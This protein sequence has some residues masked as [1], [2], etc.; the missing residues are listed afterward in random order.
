[1]NN[2]AF[3]LCPLCHGLEAKVL[4]S[5][6]TTFS[7][8]HL[9]QCNMCELTRTF[10]LPNDEILRAHDIYSYYGRNV[11]KFNSRVQKIRNLIMRM[12]AKHYLNLIP[13]LTQTP[14]ILD[15]GCAEGRL[16]KSF[17]EYGCQCWGIEHTS[18]PAQR[19]LDSDRIVYLQGDLNAMNLPEGVFDLIF[20]WHALEHM[21][22]PHL[23]MS[24]LHKLLAPKGAIIIAVPNFSS[25][26]ARRFKK[27]WFHLDIPW[28]KYHFNDKSIRHLMT[29]T[30]LMIINISSF[31]SEQGP[32]GLLQSILN[33]M[34]WPKNEFYEALKGNL[35]QRRYIYIIIQLFIGL[36]LLIP[37][38]FVSFLVS[39]KGRGS[40]IKLIL[41]KG[42]H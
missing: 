18:Y 39:I 7:E 36:F 34:G 15:V 13:D 14:K 31:C 6:S 41:K 9:V 8:F 40:V 10:P 30:H 22:N 42:K 28:H 20:L 2:K 27:F 5:A 29:E 38:F 1:M 19:F 35:T 33:A 24:Q 23:I 11:H 37:V 17:L 3:G 21:D 26:E 12:R 32:Y 4:F 16:L 25:L